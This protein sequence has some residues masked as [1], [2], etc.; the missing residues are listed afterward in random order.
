MK[1][2]ISNIYDDNTTLIY[3]NPLVSSDERM[4]NIYLMSNDLDLIIENSY[5][6]RE[7]FKRLLKEDDTEVYTYDLTKVHKAVYACLVENLQKYNMLL[8]ADNTVKLSVN[9]LDQY[10]KS[11]T[12]GQKVR[13]ENIASRVDTTTHGDIDTTTNVGQTSET[14]NIG[15]RDVTNA[16]TSFSSSDFNNTDKSSS[17]ASIDS[18]TYGSR[19]DTEKIQR[20][21]DSL[22]HGAH[23][24]TITDSAQLV[25][26]SG[27]KN[28]MQQL[29]EYRRY[30]DYN[31]LK[32]ITNDI[33]NNISY[34]LYLF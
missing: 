25:T 27:T 8:D 21:N 26:E 24:D 12:Y 33:V 29:N 34:G 30:A 20:G 4:S 3:S 17:T 19:Q 10:T 2:Q 1:I 23:Q 22:T 15:A 32:E 5:G 28:T 16:V 7:L 31:T 11:I 9:P 13:T 6:N 18:T 14:N